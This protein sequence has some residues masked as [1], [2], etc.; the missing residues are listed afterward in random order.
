SQQSR[1]IP[2]ILPKACSRRAPRRKQRRSNP[3]NFRPRVPACG[4]RALIYFVNR[5]GASGK[6][7]A[8]LKD[9]AARTREGRSAVFDDCGRLQSLAAPEDPNGRTVT[10]TPE[11]AFFN[12]GSPA[13]LRRF[14]S[15]GTP[16]YKSVA[17]DPS[18]VYRRMLFQQ[19]PRAHDPEE[20]T[21][22]RR[23]TI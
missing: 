12:T 14:P 23:E 7:V 8:M 4:L 3:K 1:L 6:K 17:G 16:E 15:S 5:G 21:I 13:N 19:V 22:D 2:P 11:T 18:L 10:E 20:P 9:Q